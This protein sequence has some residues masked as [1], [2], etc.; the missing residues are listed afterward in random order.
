MAKKKR[1]REDYRCWHPV[2]L[3]QKKWGKYPNRGTWYCTNCG[4]VITLLLERKERKQS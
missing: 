3:R 2:F 4:L 1:V